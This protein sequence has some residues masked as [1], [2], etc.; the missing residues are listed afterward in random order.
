MSNNNSEIISFNDF[1]KVKLQVG[2]ITSAE[3]LTGYNKIL[4]IV[5]DIGDKEIEIMSGIAKYYEPKDLQ[6]KLVIVCTNLEPKKF[7]DNISNGMILATE[8]KGKPVLLTVSDEVEA[9]SL[10]S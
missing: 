2:K 5:V 1:G 6:G 8:N 10:V 7:G 9:G 3:N 4:K